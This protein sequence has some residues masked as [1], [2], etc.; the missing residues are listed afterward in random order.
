MTRRMGFEQR[1]AE[2]RPGRDGPRA[3]M[4]GWWC[5]RACLARA[6]PRSLFRGD[7]KILTVGL[8]LHLRI[9]FDFGVSEKMLAGIGFLFRCLFFAGPWDGR[10]W[11]F[12]ILILQSFMEHLEASL[13]QHHWEVGRL[14]APWVFMHHQQNI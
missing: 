12:W 3:K 7:G 2:I 10:D 5:L 13:F 11:V 14:Y 9:C 1:Y 8:M 6:W 4:G